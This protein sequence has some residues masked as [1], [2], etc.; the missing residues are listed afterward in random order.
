MD[1]DDTF[2]KDPPLWMAFITAARSRGHEV[3]IV[4]M[5]YASECPPTMAED[6][7]CP[8]ICTARR[9][10]RMITDALG[11]TVDI[12]IDDSPHFVNEDA[13]QTPPWPTHLSPDSLN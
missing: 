4:T 7:G 8:V 2:T 5:R 13:Q 3:I 12:W 6:I 11:L 10:K 9:A 1:Y